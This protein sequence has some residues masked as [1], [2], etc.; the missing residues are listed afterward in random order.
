VPGYGGPA[1]LRAAVGAEPGPDTR[2]DRDTRSGQ[3]KD[4]PAGL[5]GPVR[6]AHGR[7]AAL[8]RPGEGHGRRFTTFAFIG[9]AVFVLGLVIQAL[10]TGLWRIPALA[11]YLIQAVVSVEVSFVLNRWL[12]WRDR[13]IAVRTAFARF[14]AQKIFTIALNSLI[15]AGLLHAGMNYLVANVVLTAVFTVVNYVAGDVLVF[16]RA[17]AGARRPASAGQHGPLPAAG[18]PDRTSVAARPARPVPTVSVVIPCRSSEAT[19]GATVRSLL[20]QD[21]PNL[22]EVL[23]IGSPDDSTWDGLS[24]IC[25]PR[26][27]WV[28]ISA[29][30]GRRDANFK[31][32]AGIRQLTGELVALIDSDIVLPPDWVTVAVTA[33]Q[34]GGVSCVAGGM[35]S[36]HDSFWGRY[37]DHTFLGAKTPRIA[38]SYLVTKG[39]FGTGGRKPPITA[40]ALFTRE[41]YES[42]PIDPSWSHGS[43]EDYEWFWRVTSAGYAVLVCSDL[44]GWHHHRRGLMALVREYRRSSRGC[45]YFIRAHQ[46]CPFARRRLLQ[47]VLIPLAGLAGAAAIAAAAA[48]GE[49]GRAAGLVLIFM[50]LLVAQ[51]IGCMRMRRL[52][53][54]A[55]PVAGLALGLVFTTG[56]VT[57][58]MLSAAQRTATTTMLDTA[59][60]PDALDVPETPAVPGIPAPRDAAG[61]RRRPRVP[62]LL[63]VICLVQAALSL[64]LI[65]SNTAFADEAQYLWIGRLVWAHWLHGAALPPVAGRLSGSSLLYPPLGAMASSIGGLAGARILS[66][67]FML[68]ATI[69]LYLTADRLIGRTGALAAAGLWALTTPV[70][71]LAFATYD[72]LSV[73]LTAL[74]A[75]LILQAGFRRRRGELVAAAAVMLALANATAFSGVVID[76]VVIAFAFLAWRPRMGTAAAASAT[77]W[78]LGAFAAFVCLALTV[79]HSWAAT[80]SIFAR[81][82]PD[83]QPAMLVVSDVWEYSGLVL[84]VAMSGLALALGA[85]RRAGTGLMVM[86]G[87]AGFL[88]PAGQLAERTA[89][90]LDKHLAYGIWFAAIAG[91]YAVTALIR[92]LPDGRRAAAAICCGL[93]LV[94]PAVNSWQSAWNL[95]HSWQNASSFVAALRSAMTNSHGSIDVPGP[96]EQS[97]AQYYLPQGY[98]WRRWNNVS[99]SLDP[100]MPP[101]RWRS[102]YVRRLEGGRS[103]VIALFY[104]APPGVT[105]QL[106]QTRLLTGHPVAAARQTELVALDPGQPGL[107]ELTGVLAADRNFRLAAVGPYETT[108][109]AG[110]HDY[111]FYAIWIRKA[112]G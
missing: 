48:D 14:N 36:I 105:S 110:N 67:A 18:Q 20:D 75:W 22:G 37:A 57:S 58:L 4:R 76:P 104:T 88:V 17:G 90:A 46:D 66:L 99:L 8:V 72:P 106:T 107:P 93:A 50:M 70:L 42:C 108:T 52:E 61:A 79:T 73:L 78:L 94:Y 87:L 81:T 26:L 55:Y 16:R 101:T 31:R 40:N 1:S 82:S 7:H 69:L 38:D 98:N 96:H 15:Y 102:Y 109:L 112:T 39:S 53:A 56:L 21:Y 29:P 11:T 30:P 10:L 91:G 2:A 84:V 43:Y 60:V 28:E 19:I 92:Q 25:D 54:V 32:D 77:A 47:A 45:A 6:K 103:G 41:L 85:A 3:D 80:T 9:G 68:A 49:S 5:P 64:S 86:L 71:R 12:T 35:K 44:F 62:Y 63:A 13:D 89:W 83:H 33:L 34:D 74:S 51:Q 24:G 23:L 59:P 65:W 95:Y 27:R 100:A 111:G 97:V